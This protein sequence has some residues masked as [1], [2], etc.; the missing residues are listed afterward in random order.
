MENFLQNRSKV[1]KFVLHVWGEKTLNVNLKQS[2]VTCYIHLFYYLYLYV[3]LAQVMLNQQEQ[4]QNHYL[5]FPPRIPRL[6]PRNFHRQES[7]I[8]SVLV[9]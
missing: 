3:H 7:T 2:V 4:N 8:P 6:N 9:Q 5:H 1:E